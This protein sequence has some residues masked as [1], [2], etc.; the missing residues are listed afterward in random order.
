ML[1]LFLISHVAS[2]LAELERF[3]ELKRQYKEMIERIEKRPHLYT[4]YEREETTN[5]HVARW[6][7]STS[8]Y[9]EPELVGFSSLCPLEPQRSVPFGQPRVCNS[10]INICSKKRKRCD[11]DDEHDANFAL[12]SSSDTR[13]VRCNDVS[14]RV[15][16]KR[17]R[18]WTD[19]LRDVY[20]CWLICF[21]YCTYLVHT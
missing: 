18:V 1:F 14:S 12:K 5:Q 21:N 20:Y 10:E 4:P 9:G 11:D 2:V 16:R 17:I 3:P 7:T 15:I 19:Q 8:G 13:L 6:L